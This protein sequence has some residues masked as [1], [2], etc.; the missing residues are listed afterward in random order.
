MDFQFY[1]VIHYFS[2]LRQYQMS[3]LY[4]F[5]L[6]LLENPFFLFFVPF[7]F[8]FLLLFFQDRN[9]CVFLVVLEL[10]L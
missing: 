2:I 7:S 3:V 4:T 8:F 6:N 5:R 10:P 1:S 9:L